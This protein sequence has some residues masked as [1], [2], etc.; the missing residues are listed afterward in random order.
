V[1]ELAPFLKRRGE[2]PTKLTIIHWD[3]L[4]D[5]F[6]AELRAGYGEKIVAVQSRPHFLE[7]TDRRATKGQAL[8]TLA[9]AAGIR[10]EEIVAFGDSSNDLDMIEFAGLGVAVAN[11]RPEVRRAADLV[12]AANTE[13]GVAKVIEELILI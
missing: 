6:E 7:I 3:G 11:A 5:R 10:R 4:L 13:D 8:K 2:D 9:E 1:G 12:T